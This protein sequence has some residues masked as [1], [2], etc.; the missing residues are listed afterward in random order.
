MQ[1]PKALIIWHW[2][3]L[4]KSLWFLSEIASLKLPVWSFNV[5][6]FSGDTQGTAGIENAEWIQS[7]KV[8]KWEDFTASTLKISIRGHM[9]FLSTWAPHG[10]CVVTVGHMTDE[11]FCAFYQELRE[12]NHCGSYYCKTL[13]HVWLQWHGS[14]RD[15]G[16]S[17]SRIFRVWRNAKIQ[18]CVATYN[19]ELKKT[20]T[21]SCILHTAI[22]SPICRFQSILP[23]WSSSTH[24]KAGK[25]PE[26]KCKQR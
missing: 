12:G 20:A 1:N 8:R 19:K 6:L 4:V 9:S 26:K 3:A 25:Y 23:I 5:L 11:T 18:Q 24:C 7:C 10:N 2:V 21:Y 22:V 15:N 17:G 16:H 14:F 13:W